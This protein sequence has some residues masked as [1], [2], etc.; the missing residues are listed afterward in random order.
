MAKHVQNNIKLGA[1]VLTGIFLLVLLLYLLGKNQNI[2][3]RSFILKTRFENIQGLVAGNNVRYAGIQVGTV[4]RISIIN[5]TLIEVTMMVDDEMQ[6][7]IRSNAIASIGTDGLMGN[8]LVNITPSQISGV[9]IKDNEILASKSSVDTDE[10]LRVLSKTNADVAEITESLK[11]TLKQINSSSGI[12]A[13][14]NDKSI[15]DNLRNASSRINLAMGHIAKMSMD[16][17]QIVAG[18]KNGE[19]SLGQLVGDTT[20][21]SDLESTLASFRS[22]GHHGDSLLSS[23][24]RLVSNFQLGLKNEKGTINSLLNDTVMVTKLNRSL[25][26]IEKGTAGFNQN[27]EA[28]KGSVF[29]RGYFRR[30]EKQKAAQLKTDLG[31][32]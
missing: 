17:Q 11:V 1:F 7:I 8:K 10:M 27:M 28:L 15:P 4:K 30:L 20:F 6:S 25:D 3:G 5:D 13:L 2:F 29:F 26:N 23:I 9:P 22:V 32:Q 12:W 31:L 19:G 16:M 14:L 21:A 18:V 24:D